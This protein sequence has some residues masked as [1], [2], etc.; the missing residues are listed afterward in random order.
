MIGVLRVYID[1]GNSTT[2][3]HHEGPENLPVLQTVSSLD[4][5]DL[6]FVFDIGR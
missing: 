2:Y 6:D 5:I 4:F 1:V 3:H